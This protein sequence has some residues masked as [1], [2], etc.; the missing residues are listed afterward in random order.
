MYAYVALIKTE[1]KNMERFSRCS[2]TFKNLINLV[3]RV[4]LTILGYKN[5]ARQTKRSILFRNWF[6]LIS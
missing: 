2:W 4:D 1:C 6:D 3:W 5:E